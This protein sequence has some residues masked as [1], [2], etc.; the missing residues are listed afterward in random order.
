MEQFAGL[1]IVSHGG[2]G[3]SSSQSD[4]CRAAALAGMRTLEGGGDAFD[5]A[6]ATVVVLEVDPRFNAGTGAV[7]GLDGKTAELD[8]CVMD[9]RARL[10]SAPSLACRACATLYSSPGT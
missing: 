2:A 5:G 4:G 6:I 10:G 9:S 8:A 7:L 3:G 1:T